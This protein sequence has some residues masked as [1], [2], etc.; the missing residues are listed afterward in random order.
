M[1]ARLP[2]PAPHLLQGML[3]IVSA[4]TEY[5]GMPLRPGEDE[6]VRKLLAHAHVAVGG[7]C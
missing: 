3:E 4:A 1:L 6:T 2:A 7:C 5:D